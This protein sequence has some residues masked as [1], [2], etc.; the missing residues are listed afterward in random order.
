MGSSASRIPAQNPKRSNSTKR[1]KAIKK[2][3]PN[4]K[5]TTRTS[6][7]TDGTITTG[8]TQSPH[9]LP[10]LRPS[11][12]PQGKDIDI[13]HPIQKT[14]TV[15]AAPTPNQGNESR[16]P[17]RIRAGGSKA[18]RKQSQK[19]TAVA[20]RP[21]I[22][23]ATQKPSKTS[24]DDNSL[25][26]DECPIH[27][28]SHHDDLINTA[29]TLVTTVT[30]LQHRPK[31]VQSK[32][33]YRIRKVRELAREANP[34]KRIRSPSPSARDIYDK[35]QPRFIQLVC[36]W[37]GCA[38]IL[39]NMNI[40]RKH[41]GVAHG[42]EAGE[43]RICQWGSCRQPESVLGRGEDL[44]SGSRVAFAT[45]QE[46]GDHVD[47]DHLTPLYWHMGDGRA[48]DGI[49]FQEV[50]KKPAKYLLCEGFQITPSVQGQK[51]ETITEWRA[52]KA[53][54][55]EVLASALCEAPGEVD[56]GSPENINLA[57]GIAGCI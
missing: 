29:H 42:K 16:K 54:L 6:P 26:P 18:S 31:R 23:N 30:E 36:E 8:Q 44:E 25:G 41:I 37:K 2:G 20:T 17:K 24:Y 52:R 19:D 39:N 4:T 40:L 43:E 21:I 55:R 10:T 12:Q 49:V 7:A 38:A 57:R 13:F 35:L 33:D 3:R 15:I 22:A 47:D 53:L 11:P 34:N 1:S 27:D 48:G 14:E 51:I 28:A 46:L 5:G 56:A 32:P 50:I 9:S 45:V